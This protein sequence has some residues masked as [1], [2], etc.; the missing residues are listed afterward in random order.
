MHGHTV[1][2][3]LVVISAILALGLLTASSALAAQPDVFTVITKSGVD[4]YYS[5]DP[6]CGITGD[7]TLVYNNVFHVTDR[8]D[9]GFI[10]FANVE[11]DETIVGDNGVTYTGHAHLHFTVIAPA[12]GA[13][14]YIQ[15]LSIN[16]R[17]DDGSHV[18]MTFVDLITLNAHGD[19]T[20]QF[21]TAVCH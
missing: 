11:A 1:R 20:T 15:T 13:G 21:N 18:S 3:F 17:G 10:L 8:G 7:V 16:L 12:N 4:S 6:Q 19:V 2:R 9:A 14:P 5:S